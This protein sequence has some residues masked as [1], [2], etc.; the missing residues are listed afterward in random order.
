M[1]KVILII[2]AIIGFCVTPVVAQY[3][4]GNPSLTYTKRSKKNLKHFFGKKRHKG[5]VSFKHRAGV[6][7]PSV[8][9]ETRRILSHRRYE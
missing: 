8:K 3:S 4:M 7:H 9:K 2:I 1:K 6:S 5:Y